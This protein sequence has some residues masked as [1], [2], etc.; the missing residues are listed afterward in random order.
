MA[1]DNDQRY[2]SF[3]GTGWSFPPTFSKTAAGVEMVR[4]EE[5][6]RQSLA[7]L[8]STTVGERIME[9]RYGCDLDH[10]LFEPL[11]T[12]TKTYVAG[13]VEHAIL[14][15]EPRIDLERLTI[16]TGAAEEGRV[17]IVIEYTVRGTNS[18]YNLVYPF[19]RTESGTGSAT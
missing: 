6:I 14:L 15:Y 7:I 13:L 17:D 18:R 1:N 16:D 4:D 3:L 11:N 5:D 12:T 10:L 9:P 19:Y 2:T 8:L